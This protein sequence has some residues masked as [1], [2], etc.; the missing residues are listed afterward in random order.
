MAKTQV[1]NVQDTKNWVLG[2][3]TSEIALRANVTRSNC[4]GELNELCRLGL[5]T[6]LPGRPTRY[7]P[8]DTIHPLAVNDT[9][10]ESGVHEFTVSSSPADLAGSPHNQSPFPRQVDAFADVVGASRS[11]LEAVRLAKM[12]VGY[13]PRGM[14]ALLLGEA[15]VG[16]S[17][18]AQ[19]MHSYAVEIGKVRP[20]APFISFNCAEYANNPEI[21]LD[22]LFGH[23]KGAFTGAVES[24][25]GLVE[26]ADGGIL[27]LDEIHRL[28]PQGQE[29]L[30]HW[31]D[32]GQFR[33]MGEVTTGRYSQALLIAATTEMDESVLL[34]TFRRRIPVTIHLPSLHDWSIYDRYE[35]IYRC[36]AE[37]AEILNRPIRLTSNAVDKLLFAHLPGNIGN[38]KNVLKLACARAYAFDNQNVELTIGRHHIQLAEVERVSLSTNGSFDKFKDI[39]VTPSDASIPTD[40]AIFEESLYGHLTLLS[41]RLED[42]GLAQDEIV[43]AIERELLRWQFAKPVNPSLT[44]LRRFVGDT[45]YSW[46]RSSW[47]AV[48][49]RVDPVVTEAGF[50]RIC[51]HLSG[52]TRDLKDAHASIEESVLQHI[53]RE[54]TELCSIAES[55]LMAFA[56][57]SGVHLPEHE[58]PLVA[59]LL[60]P[61]AQM[62]PSTIGLVLMMR[63]DGLATRYAETARQVTQAP[64]LHSI[65]VP[66]GADTGWMSEQ[67]HRALQLANVGRGVLV[68]TDIPAIQQLTYRQ[69]DCACI[70]RPDVTTLLQA[71]FAAE[72]GINT[73]DEL[74]VPLQA[75]Q[76]VIDA[77]LQKVQKRQVWTCCMTGRGSALALKRLIE[78][79]V[80]PDILQQIDIVP[81]EVAPTGAPS[82]PPENGVIAMVGSVRPNVPGIPFLSVEELLSPHGMERLV[83]VVGHMQSISVV[84][85]TAGAVSEKSHEE[86][87]ELFAYAASMLE[88]DIVFVNPK[89]ALRCAKE[90]IAILQTETTLTLDEA[91]QVRFA[92]HMAYVVERAVRNEALDHHSMGAIPSEIHELWEL[93]VR[94]LAP[95]ESWFQIELATGEIGYICDMLV[96]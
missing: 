71:L 63:G 54:Y 29:L 53:R 20:D 9:T 89:L 82:V 38:L 8:A 47:N 62:P 11:L 16:K 40:T 51:M 95:Y 7:W 5:V 66:F 46:M 61:E 85:A 39:C 42:I 80:S 56:R 76:R 50:I 12:S 24:K 33:R 90:A 22:H 23:V 4:S 60:K 83:N 64:N 37:E 67:F 44:E 69:A 75:S 19:T 10:L 72:S 92:I 88:N 43:V 79:S 84:A 77:K 96:M 34:L 26:M 36:L 86:P 14:H 30:F 59:L 55:L 49:H 58:V 31:L 94:A 48:V 57:E 74:R 2:F 3:D 70:F 45:F 73:L 65:D 25:P 1:I 32:H 21:L 13:P 17:T 27:F 81:V 15:G 41:E 91:W 68:L 6:K 28:P 52:L 78:N 87:T 93:V 35:L 18:F